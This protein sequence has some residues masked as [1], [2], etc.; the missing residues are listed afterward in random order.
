M[1]KSESTALC[2]GQGRKLLGRK[3]R[4]ERIESEAGQRAYR[5][6]PVWGDVPIGRRPKYII[7]LEKQVI[8]IDC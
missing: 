4:K 5:G 1:S 7:V 6:K 8:V 2:F 3:D